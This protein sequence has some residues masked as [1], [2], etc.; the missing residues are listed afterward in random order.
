MRMHQ[1][2]PDPEPDDNRVDDH[3]DDEIDACLRLDKPVSFFL[4]A[5]AGSGKTRSVVTALSHLRARHG[6]RLRLQGQ[7]VGV[8]TYT[9]A[10]CDEIKSR[11]EYDPLIEVSTIHSFVWSLIKGFNEDIRQWLRTQ[12]AAEIAEL[13][14]LLR[15]GRPGTKTAINRAES[16]KLKHKRLESLPQIRRFTYNPLDDNRGRDSLSHT[17][18]IK[19]GADFVTRKPVMKRLLVCRFPVLLI[20]ESQ[21]TNKLLMEAFLKLQEEYKSQFCLGLFGDTMQRIYGDGKEDLG[22]Q[23]PPD[24]AKPAKALNHRCPR[25]IIRLINRI[26][27]A[28]DGQEQR[29][30]SDSEEGVVR[31]FILPGDTIDK[32][33]AERKVAEEMAAVTADPL[34][35]GA[36]ADIKTLILEHHIAARRMG[37]LEMFQ[38][39]YEIDGLQTGLRDGSLSGLRLFSQLISP[40]LKAHGRGDKFAL[41]AIVRNGSPLLSKASLVSAG[42][43]QRAQVRQARDAVNELMGLCSNGGD[44]RFLDILRCIWRTGLFE[45]PECLQTMAARDDGDGEDEATGADAEDQDPV[46]AAWRRF[47]LTK[48]VQIEPYELYVSGQAA[49]ETHQGVKGREFPRVMVVMD[50]AEARGFLFSYEKLFT[51]KDKTKS[52]LDNERD[53]KETGLD[54]TRRLFYVTCSRAQRSLALVAYTSRPDKVREYVV[55]EGWLEEGEVRVLA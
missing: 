41:A 43:D 55:R 37:F 48:F 32:T 46:Q 25:R 28:V 45:I 31:L 29:P 8:I 34:W 27:S 18:V 44:P 4:F 39:L 26:R 7:R 3:V 22:R 50:D 17:E 15:K 53:G 35:T 5:G 51:A 6:G 9:N 42:T 36:A 11:L 47:L 49:F 2:P 24:W 12:L 30:R 19:I 16:V 10:A 13:E 14:E 40:I 33:A 21:D 54:R 38:P 20:D 23:L 52:D 1:I